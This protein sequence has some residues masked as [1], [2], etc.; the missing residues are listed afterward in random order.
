MTYV[1][2]ACALT[3]F[4]NQEQGK[5]FEPVKELF[6]RAVDE[7]FPVYMN[8]VN[9]AEVYYFF[10]RK[11]GQSAADEIM[12]NAVDLPITV[13][14]TISEAVYRRTAYFKSHYSMSLAD[15]FVCA[16]AQCLGATLVTKDSEVEA[17]EN[18]ESL[19]VFWIK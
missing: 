5:G 14:D 7:G 13:I 3:A 6:E 17:A 15:A 19:S 10:I 1:L 8:I 18:K 11:K 16:T 4:L 12:E 2:D 9:L